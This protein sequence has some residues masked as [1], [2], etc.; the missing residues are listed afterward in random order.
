MGHSIFCIIV[1]V[2]SAFFKLYQPLIV[3]YHML[4]T[5]HIMLSSPCLPR[6]TCLHNRICW[7]RTQVL[8]SSTCLFTR[9]RGPVRWP[10]PPSRPL[11]PR[12]LCYTWAYVRNL[13]IL[14]QMTLTHCFFKES[15]GSPFRDPPSG[16]QMGI[17]EFFTV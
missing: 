7:Y 10:A 3:K 12:H 5:H 2:G 1:V 16:G 17:W 13:R 14:R 4:L 9:M 15:L 11:S 6:N 8:P